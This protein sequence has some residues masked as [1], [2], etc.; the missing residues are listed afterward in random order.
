[1]RLNDLNKI[2]NKEYI[3]LLPNC[4]YDILE[5]VEY[6]F[7]NVFFL[8]YEP[9]KNEIEN[10]INYVN[11]NIKQLLLFDYDESYRAILPYIKKNKKVKWI[12]KHSLSEMTDPNVRATFLGIT[13][14]YDRNI[15]DLIGCLNYD[16]YK[17][18][19]NSG[20]NV[21]HITIDVKRIK[22]K[23]SLNS[24]SVGIIGN[25]YNPNHNFYNELSALKMV[26]Y[27]EVKLIS[28]MPATLHFIEFFNIR[29]S[30]KD[31]LDDVI[32]NNAVNLYCNF[33]CNNIEVIL[34][35]MD[36]GVP[37]LLGN[38]D[39]FDNYKILKEYLVLK[40]DDDINE[41]SNK[42]KKIKENYKIIMNEYDKFRN[43]YTN[44]SKKQIKDFLV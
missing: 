13:E 32:K 42:I 43:N 36:Y 17:V 23:N 35:S 7:E 24:K 41:I 37:C 29:A 31:K 26:D 34:K 44:N 38:N 21:K 4:D 16:T 19:K 30:L 1:M 33:S 12:F 39:I 3:V 18:L 25:D 40:S 27:S 22:N 11:E 5:G 9:T 8:N 2:K 20:Y 10:L 28:H 15:V 6:T 14:F